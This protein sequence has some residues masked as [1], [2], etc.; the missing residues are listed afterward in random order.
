MSWG[1]WY[2]SGPWGGCVSHGPDLLAPTIGLQSPP[3]GATFVPGTA[4]ISFRLSDNLSGVDLGSII[5]TIQQGGMP[6]QTLFVNG[7]FTPLFR[8]GSFVSGNLTNGF[9]FIIVPVDPWISGA[10]VTVTV[11][12]ADAQC[13]AAMFAWTFQATPC[14]GCVL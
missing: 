6:I 3:N 14:F 13:N 11:T 10:P 12:A 8:P 9:D 7:A 2:G 4:P 1:L 5:V